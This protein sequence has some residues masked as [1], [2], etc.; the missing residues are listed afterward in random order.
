M[1]IPNEAIFLIS[2]GLSQN[3]KKSILDSSGTIQMKYQ[4]R[5]LKRLFHK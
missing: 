1:G 5:F 3:Y 2:F 4:N